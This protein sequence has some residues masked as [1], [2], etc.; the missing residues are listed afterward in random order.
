MQLIVFSIFYLQAARLDSPRLLAKHFTAKF[1]FAVACNTVCGKSVCVYVL[2][3]PIFNLNIVLNQPHATVLQLSTAATLCRVVDSISRLRIR[4][5]VRRYLLIFL[6]RFLF[7]ALFYGPNRGLFRHSAER[8]LKKPSPTSLLVLV[9][10]V[11]GLR[12]FQVPREMVEI[13]HLEFMFEILGR[14]VGQTFEEL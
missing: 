7:Q 11:F 13:L 14:K 12:L 8:H 3:V 1:T 4:R 6:S 2:C 5:V 9:V 10:V